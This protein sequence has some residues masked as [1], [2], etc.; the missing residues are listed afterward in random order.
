M[1]IGRNEK[2]PCG[3]GIKYKR[4]H[5]NSEDPMLIHDKNY[6]NLKGKL[7]EDV[8]QF[9]AEKTFLTDWCYK[10]P[11]IEVGKELCDLLIVFGDIAIIWQI[12]DLRLDDEGQYNKSEVEKNLRQLSGAHRAL[13]GTDKH[14][15]LSNPRRGKEIFD[16]KQIK[17]VFLISALMGEGEGYFSPMEEINGLSVHVFNR[18][19]TQIALNELDTI[20]DF[21]TYLYTK[22]KFLLETKTQITVLGGEKELLAFYLLNGRSFDRLSKSDKVVLDEG[23]WKHIN[24]K[25]EFLAKKRAD[26]ISYAWDGMISR[27]HEGGSPTY[28]VIAREMA[29]L[30]RFDR[31]FLTKAFLDA[32]SI[33]QSKN[34]DM[35]R[36]YFEVGDTT[37]CFLYMDDPEPRERRKQILFEM[38][39]VARG[40]FHKN[41]KVLGIATEKKIEL[42][43]SYD[44][45]L[46]DKPIWSNHDKENVKKLQ[47]QSG[48]LVSPERKM[49][50]EDEYPND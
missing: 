47:E 7:A 35:Y 10:N 38:C 15:E 46:L 18:E 17:Q 49:V 11:T 4:C 8:V 32:W 40:K 37:Y 39:Y 22:E 12:K 36:R 23:A 14:V 9:L 43:C 24:K 42:E 1:K 31:R 6:F 21:V 33:S 27:A 19:F 44:F 28:E 48:L 45:C 41:I 25:P 2:C 50:H 3:S 20:K 29:A 26:E 13:L 30:N 5:L 16:P 34:E